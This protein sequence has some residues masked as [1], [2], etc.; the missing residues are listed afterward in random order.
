M[1]TV[2]LARS[3]NEAGFE[4]IVALKVIHDHLAGEKSFVDMFLDEARIAAN[5]NHPN[6]CTVFDFGVDK[7][8]YYLAMEYLLGEPLGRIIRT[9]AKRQKKDEVKEL[10]WY[11]ARV[12][13]D[14]C[15]GLHAAHELTDATGRHLGVVHRDVSPENIIVTYGRCGEAGGLRRR[16]GRTADS[17]NQ[18]QQDQGQVRVRVPRA[19]AEYGPGSPNRSLG[20]WCGVFGSH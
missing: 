4:K 13:A 16:E 14:A 20:R 12:L 17:R 1:A 7:G 10:P 11:L 15:E 5:I 2:Y 9:I 8:I 3:E 18:S 6:V 19:G